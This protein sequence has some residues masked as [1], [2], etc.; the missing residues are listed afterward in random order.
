MCGV[1]DLQSKYCAAWLDRSHLRPGTKNIVS[2]QDWSRTTQKIISDQATAQ[3][4]P[5]PK[6]I[7]NL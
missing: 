6:K 4:G 7:Q 3:S 1:T 5:D 2:G